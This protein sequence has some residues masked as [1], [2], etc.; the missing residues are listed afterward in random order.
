M[1]SWGPSKS[2]IGRHVRCPCPSISLTSS[3]G[4]VY[5]NASQ[6]NASILVLGI[7]AATIHIWA[8]W[9]IIGNQHIF[10]HSFTQCQTHY[11]QSSS[12]MGCN[13]STLIC[14]C[15]SCR[16]D[17]ACRAEP[18]TTSP[19]S[20]IRTVGDYKLPEPTT[21]HPA[22][23]Q[24]QQIQDE[25]QQN[26][27]GDIT[28]AKSVKYPEFAHLADS[29]STTALCNP[30]HTYQQQNGWDSPI[31]GVMPPSPS[32]TLSYSPQQKCWRNPN[33]RP[34]PIPDLMSYIA[35]LDT[36]EPGGSEKVEDGG[37]SWWW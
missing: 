33:R 28:E 26:S 1:A 14:S 7:D 34:T 6:R 25:H 3:T 21:E 36:K 37:G 35:K 29:E 5:P 13:F 27:L 18:S 30:R 4:T 20:Q 8:P 16:K 19:T 2:H 31:N 10:F 9:I 22:F 11:P 17:K 24:P 12:I 32:S 23:R 15:F